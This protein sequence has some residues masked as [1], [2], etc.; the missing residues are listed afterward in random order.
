[1]VWWQWWWW[2]NHYVDNFFH[3]TFQCDKSVTNIS[4]L[5]STATVSI[6]NIDVIKFLEFWDFWHS[7]DSV[8]RKRNSDKVTIGKR[9]PFVWWNRLLNILELV[10][11]IHIVIFCTRSYKNVQIEPFLSM[12]AKML[13]LLNVKILKNIIIQKTYKLSYAKCCNLSNSKKYVTSSVLATCSLL[14]F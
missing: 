10:L 14:S 6:T 7:A 12:M 8:C 1:M 5:S 9:H 3:V 11:T 2:Q 4:N 13:S